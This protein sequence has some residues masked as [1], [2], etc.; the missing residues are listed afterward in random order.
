MFIP[1]KFCLLFTA[2]L[3]FGA[4]SLQITFIASLSTLKIFE[5]RTLSC[6]S[7]ITGLVW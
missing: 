7:S 1:F 6:V 2:Y 3:L 4:V 5:V